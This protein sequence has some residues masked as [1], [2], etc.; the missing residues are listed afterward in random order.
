MQF[1]AAKSLGTT[2]PPTV[3]GVPAGVGINL[4]MTQNFTSGTIAGKR[5]R[6]IGAGNIS[7]RYASFVNMLGADVAVWDPY[8]SEPCFHRAGLGRNGTF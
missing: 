6:I 3:W 4:A 8:A 7:S 1:L 2:K 5:V